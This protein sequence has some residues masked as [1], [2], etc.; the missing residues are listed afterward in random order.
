MSFDSGSGD[1]PGK[2]AGHHAGLPLIRL[3]RLLFFGLVLGTSLA[4][5]V[6]MARILLASGIS[7]PQVLIFVLF[8]VTFTWISFSFWTAA[9]GFVLQLLRID[10]LSLGRAGAPACHNAHPGAAPLGRT[11]LVMPIYNEDPTRVILGL[12]ATCRSLLATGQAGAFDAY[13]LSDSTDPAIGQAEE[14]AVIG[15]RARLPAGM[16]LYYRRRSD[17]SGRKAGNLADFCRR[18]GRHY[19][20]MVVLD[21]D[22]LMAG[23][24]LVELALAMEASPATGLIQT[25]PIPVRQH[26]LFGRF[27]QFA[28]CLYSPMLATGQSFWQADAAN[29]W[30][31]NAII[32]VRAFTEYCGLPTLRGKP[33]LGGEILSHDFVEAALMRRAGWEVR[34]LPDIRGSYEEL[35]AN[36]LDYAKRDRRWTQGN[37]QHL[38]LIAGRGLHPLSRLHFLMGAVAYGASLF[39]LLMLAAST[40][41]AIVRANTETRFFSFGYQL[42]PDWPVSRAGL[43]LSLLLITLL[44]LMLPKVLGLVLALLRQRQ[45]YGG[46]FR[47]TLSTILEAAFAILIAP[48]MMAL[49][50]WF[51]VSIVCGRSIGWGTQVREGRMVPW[52]EAL[53]R[54][55]GASLVALVWGLVA[56]VHAPD[57]VWWLAPVLLGLVLAA[58]I[59]RLGSS[60]GAGRRMRRW[61]LL[62]APSEVSADEVLVR[63]SRLETASPVQAANAGAGYLPVL[64]MEWPREMPAQVMSRPATGGRKQN[65]PEHGV[66]AVE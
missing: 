53:L 40:A 18:W 24:T 59:V 16:Q 54:T 2:P 52:S 62:L 66:R 47:L 64:P 10:P 20:F 11:A 41:D 31:H 25:V 58:P 14:Q 61:G 8:A 43:I 46:A 48:V 28:A 17:N 3:R 56:A 26:T 21:A 7:G 9:A 44:M 37:L 51:V 35:P 65:T 63:L 34:L 29:Y 45:A 60:P 15:L 57:F 19:A 5:M 50:A 22:S 49:H 36:L 42:F 39:W 4:G 55:G 27:L 6:M 13:L 12:E 32:R 23:A 33:P 30:G 1:A 38:R